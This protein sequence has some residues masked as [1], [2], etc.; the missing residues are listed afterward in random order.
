MTETLCPVRLRA[1][2]KIIKDE[3]DN[4]TEVPGFLRWATLNSTAHEV[5]ILRF[6]V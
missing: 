2:Q 5:E 3:C 1:G 6:K 4:V